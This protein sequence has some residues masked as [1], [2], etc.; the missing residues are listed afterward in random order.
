MPDATYQHGLLEPTAKDLK[1][2]VVVQLE[3]Y[4]FCRLDA[5]EPDGTR[6]FWYTHQ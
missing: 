1:P 4:G 3:R 6:T 5:V 2:G